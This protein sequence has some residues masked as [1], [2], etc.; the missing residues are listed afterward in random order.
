MTYKLT[1]PNDVTT[2]IGDRHTADPLWMILGVAY[3]DKTE[4]AEH[5]ERRGYSLSRVEQ[6]PADYLERATRLNA[7]PVKPN[8]VI[9]DGAH[10]DAKYKIT[11]PDGQTQVDIRDIIAG[12]VTA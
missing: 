5:L 9:A 2:I 1:A 3:T 8:N 11:G 7:Y 10:P 12:R 6:T 4:V